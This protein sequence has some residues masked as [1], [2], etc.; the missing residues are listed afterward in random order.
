VQGTVP[1]VMRVP[2]IYNANPCDRGTA[3]DS[4]VA[5]YDALGLLAHYTATSGSKLK[6]VRC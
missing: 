3:D 6:T 1:P 5:A 4:L 2:Y